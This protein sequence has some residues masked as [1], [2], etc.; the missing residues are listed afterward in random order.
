MKKRGWIIYNGNLPGNKFLDYAQWIQ[1]AASKQDSQTIIIKNNE[2]LSFLGT[3]Q[4]ELL[5][6]SKMELP[7]Y[8]VFADKDIYLARQLEQL[9]LRVFNSSHAIESSDDKI[10]TYQQLAINKLPIPKTIIAPKIFAT[11]RIDS[12]SI[13]EAIGK[14]GFPMII[15][16]AFGSFGEQVYLVN[17]EEELN[18]KVLEL[19]GKAFM[20]QEFVSSS[21]GRDMRLQ[22]VGDKVVAAMKRTAA[23]DFR[24]NVTAGGK[25]A[26]YQPT[27]Q[28]EKLAILATKAIEADFAGVDLLFGPDKNAL[29]CEINSNAHIHNMYDCTGINAADYIVEYILGQPD[30]E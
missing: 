1:E 21:Y 10:T 8:V 15:K 3:N 25:M 20:F 19:Q 16:E 14:L 18:L 5:A 7:D 26:A 4:L 29:V 11:G 30:D 6:A 13:E 28:E 22:V 9:G 24:A 2:L 17:S 12:K 27:E 23:N